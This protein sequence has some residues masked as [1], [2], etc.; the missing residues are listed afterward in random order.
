MFHNYTDPTIIKL[1][2][3]EHLCASSDFR[4]T[5]SPGPDA[6]DRIVNGGRVSLS[7]RKTILPV[8]IAH[9]DRNRLHNFGIV[10]SVSGNFD[11][12]QL[13]LGLYIRGSRRSI[14]V[15][16]VVSIQDMGCLTSLVSLNFALDEIVHSIREGWDGRTPSGSTQSN[17][18]PA[19]FLRGSRILI[20]VRSRSDSSKKN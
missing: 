3:S 8:P 12:F 10:P 4:A 7:I 11:T 15:R 2:A 17:I 9:W 20:L 6:R 13:V 16:I 18:L 14:A 5:S 1:S 19:V